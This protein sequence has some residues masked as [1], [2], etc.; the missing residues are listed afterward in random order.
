MS[1]TS[2]HDLY[3]MARK[4]L[5]TCVRRPFP[6]RAATTPGPAEPVRTTEVLAALPHV[7]NGNYEGDHWLATLA[8]HMM[9]A[10]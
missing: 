1:Q 7:L 4:D 10:G 9:E 8:V 2:I 6:K 5:Y 3:D